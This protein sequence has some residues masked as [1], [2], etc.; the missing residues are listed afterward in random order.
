MV[1][2]YAKPVRY[3]LGGEWPEG[4]WVYP[5]RDFRPSGSGRAPRTGVSMD[6]PDGLPGALKGP[7]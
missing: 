5:H 1:T 7:G 6:R 2:R 4:V 3:G